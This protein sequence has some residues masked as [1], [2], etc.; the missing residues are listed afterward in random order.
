MKPEGDKKRAGAG[1]LSLSKIED[2]LSASLKSVDA[3]AWIREVFPSYLVYELDGKCYQKSWGII[4]GN[5]TLGSDTKE[6]ERVWVETRS[7]QAET[8]ES[9]EI[10]ATL[11]MSA[12]PEGSAWDVTICEPGFTKNGWYIPDEA[13]RTGAALFENVD[14][15]LYEMPYGASHISDPLFDVKNLLVKNKAG[16]IDGVKHQ[17]GQ[18]LNGVLHFLDSA[19][20]LGKNL[21]AAMKTGKQVYG[22]SYD[23]PVRATKAEVDGRQVFKVLKFL[24]ADS[25]DIVTRPA[26]GGKFNRAVASMSAQNNQEVGMK[27]KIWDL[28]FSKRPDLLKG[29]ELEKVTDD[30]VEALARMA[31]DKPAEPAA[32]AQNFAVQVTKEDLEILRCGMALDQAL[33][34]KCKLPDLAKNRIR[35]AFTDRTFKTEDLTTAINAEMDYIAKMAEQDQG[36]TPIPGSS[37]AVGIGTIERAQMAVD[38]MFG[39]TKDEMVGFSRMERLDHEPFFLDMRSRMDYSGFED[40]PAFKGLRDMYTFFTGDKEVTGRF[41]RNNMPADLRAKMDITSSTFSYVLGNTLARRLVK[42]YNAVNYHEDLLISVRKSVSDFRQQEA[43]NVGYF[44]DLDTI[45]PETSDYDEISAVTDEE[46]TYT[47]LQKGNLL[48]ITRKTI[49]ND[50]ITLIQRL[51]NRLGRAARRTHG[52]YVWAFYTGNATC[53]DGTAWFTSGHGNLGANALSFTYALAAYQAIAKMTEKDSGER[54]ALLDDPSI[55]PVLVYP[56]DLI[57]TGESIVNDDEYF[58]SNDLTTKTRNPLKGKITGKMVSLLTDANDWGMLLPPSVVDMV[59]MGYLNGRQEPEM[60]VADTPQSE[61]VF[62]ADKIRHKIRHEYAG[63]V[64]AYQSGYKAIVT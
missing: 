58:T 57:A 29:K 3:N 27:K 40:V 23:C 31:M 9:I 54:I 52:K 55:K 1:E 14:V 63:A 51:I 43:V 44:G 10:T 46:S 5:V 2:L 7:Q 42:D 18:G 45:D 15:N 59:E 48:T 17:A 49:I 61:Q 6:V 56:V 20:W 34:D 38:R 64:V 11:K 36:N 39:L 32:T 60:F 37:I 53:S 25:V 33:G 50:D 28:I 4:D 30:E 8:D 22:L 47:I 13:I 12:D 62:V 16:W 41:M 35:A 19:K 21:L 26:A 24:A